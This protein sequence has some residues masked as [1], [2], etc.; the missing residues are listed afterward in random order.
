MGGDEELEIV[1]YAERPG[2]ATE[3]VAVERVRI[4]KR[5]VT[6]EETVSGEVRREEIE[7]DTDP[8]GPR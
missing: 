4:G 6:A 7:L 5:T 2:V 3:T 1:L 8:E